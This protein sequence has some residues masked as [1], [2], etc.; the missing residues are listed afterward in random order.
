MRTLLEEAGLTTL[1]PCLVFLLD[2]WVVPLHG[3]PISWAHNN[4]AFHISF[5]SSLVLPRASLSTATLV[6]T[7]VQCG[8]LSP[9]TCNRFSSYLSLNLL[10]LAP[11]VNVTGSELMGRSMTSDEMGD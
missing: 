10:S 3:T 5:A 8:Q 2:F 4:I 11:E 9:L 1:S 6:Q 7:S